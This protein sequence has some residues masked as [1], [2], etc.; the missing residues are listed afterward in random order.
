M[1][2]L[3]GKPGLLDYRRCATA[4]R[5]KGDD[6]KW[7]GS[8]RVFTADPWMKDPKLLKIEL[9]PK[10][11]HEA[12]EFK[13]AIK[14]V[15]KQKNQAIYLDE[16]FHASKL[17]KLTPEIEDLMTRGRSL[18]ITVINGLQRPVQVSRFAISQS[19]HIISFH[20]E[21]RDAKTLAEATTPRIRPIL[22]KL[23]KYQFV[24]YKEDEPPG[25]DLWVGRLQDLWA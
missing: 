11:G 4:L 6:A 1:Y 2:G 24:W 23:E 14:N 21:G 15:W 7:L 20:Q 19:T 22:E 16:L 8:K 10:R 18:G 25:R 17:L 5:S 3:G 12:A 13:A 9:F